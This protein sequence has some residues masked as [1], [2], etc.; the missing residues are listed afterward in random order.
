MSDTFFKAAMKLGLMT[1]CGVIGAASFAGTYYLRTFSNS[2]KKYKSK[3]ADSD[4]CI[5]KCQGETAA[6]AAKLQQALWFMS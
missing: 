6:Y 3:A 4:A 5:A 1:A 2:D